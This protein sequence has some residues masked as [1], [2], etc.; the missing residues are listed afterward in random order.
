MACFYTMAPVNSVSCRKEWF[1]NRPSFIHHCDLSPACL[2]I[3][4]NSLI[5]PWFSCLSDYGKTS[6][7]LLYVHMFLLYVHMWCRVVIGRDWAIFGHAGTGR[8]GR[9]TQGKIPWNIP[10]WLGIEPG[11]RR[12]QTVRCIHSPIE[13][14]WPRARRGQTVR[15]IHSP[16]MTDYR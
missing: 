8:V 14:S 6:A 4:I 11:P 9:I 16:I 13:P 12:G 7:F 1:I 2:G 10:P 3:G 15:C 5:D